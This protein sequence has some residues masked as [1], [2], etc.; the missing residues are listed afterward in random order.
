M[1]S[2]HYICCIYSNELQINL[3]IEAQTMDPDK[4]EQS[5]LD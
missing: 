2:G 4:K 5:D 3:I 1:L